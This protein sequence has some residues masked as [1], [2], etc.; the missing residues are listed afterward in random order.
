ME[1]KKFMKNNGVIIVKPISRELAKNICINN[2][3]SKKWNTSFGKYNFGIFKSNNIEKCLGCAVFG[4]LMNPKSYKSICDDITS[5]NIVELNRLWVD[6]ELGHNTETVFLSLCFKWLK[7][8][9]NI[10][11]VQSFADG[12]L[13]CGTIYKAS[14]F[15]YYGCSKTLFFENIKTGETIH[16]VPF[17]NTSRLVKMVGENLGYIRGYFKPFYVK[18]YRYIYFID[19][20]YEGKCLLKREKYPEYQKGLDYVEYKHPCTLMARCLYATKKIGMV[21]LT[22]EFLEFMNDNFSKNEIKE[23]ID[24]AMKNENLNKY[25]EE[26]NKDDVIKKINKYND[27]Y[28]N[29][30]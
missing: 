23:S 12:R 10:K 11:L 19:K 22:K 25:L 6:D 3:Y 30:I 26:K 27:K 29:N 5:D 15:K 14:N 4:N 28:K 9:T 24:V 21:D 2:H 7:H 20:E 1:L 13:G 17:E 18:T 8:N 16:K